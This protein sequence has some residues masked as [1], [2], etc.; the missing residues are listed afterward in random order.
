MRAWQGYDA[1]RGMWRGYYRVVPAWPPYLCPMCGGTL[2]EEFRCTGGHGVDV[3]GGIPWF[4]DRDNYARSFGV[5]WLRHARTQLDSHTGLPIT[6]NRAT[7][8][9]G[10]LWDEL[11]DRHVLEAGCG[12]GRFTEL[13][14]E[15]GAFV[16][17]V[18]LSQAV[19]VNHER[20]G[21][22]S[23]HRVAAASILDLPFAPGQFDVVFCA[24][25][26]Q[27][28]PDSEQ[29]IAA[30]WVQVKPGGWL[31]FDHYRHNLST[32]TRTAWMFRLVL[33]RLSPE[34]GMRATEKLVRVLLPL[35]RRA[36]HHRASEMVLN[37][38]S[39]V[40]SHYAGYPDLSERDQVDW[41]LLNTHDNL[42]DYYKRHRTAGHLRRTVD[43]LGAVD[44]GVRKMPYTVE[45]RARRP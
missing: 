23:R 38:L 30:L 43:A 2:G 33:R 4:V 45:V 8:L 26:I 32:W 13:L 25:V 20:F 29:A 37:R 10:P 40:T 44:V 16:S 6:R 24:G 12:A 9:L 11:E 18:D 15:R 22:H 19:E 1:I 27:H 41:A 21:G 5:Q 42:T 7:R 36:A 39:P 3:H 34:A 31:V 28:T 14:L 17:A 35:H